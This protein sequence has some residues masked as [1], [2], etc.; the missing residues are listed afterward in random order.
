MTKKI[1][2]CDLKPFDIS[3]HLDDLAAITEYINIVLEDNDPAILASLIGDISRL[4]I[5]NPHH[6]IFTFASFTTC[7]HRS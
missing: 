1:K 6:S 7:P 2:I 3:E 5:E 4:R